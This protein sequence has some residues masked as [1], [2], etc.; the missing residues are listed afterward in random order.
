L[1]VQLADIGDLLLAAPAV[2][3]FARARPGL[4][5]SLLTKPANRPLAER[6]FDDVITADKHLYDRPA[7][8]ARPG[9]LVAAAR[10]VLA[11]RR[12]KF[13]EVIL[14][15]HLTT[16]FGAAKWALLSL[17]TG[18]KIRRG[19]DNGRGWFLSR[20]T[21]DRGFGAANEETYWAEMLAGVEA[22]DLEGDD[23]AAQDL[24]AKNGVGGQFAVLHPGSGSYSVARR[25]PL[26]HYAT[27]ARLLA[28]SL[29]LRIVVVGGPEESELGAA[30]VAAHPHG[31]VSLSGRTDFPTLVAVLR[32]AAIFVGNNAGVAQIASSLGT[33]SV[34]IFGPTSPATWHVPSPTSRAVRLD[35]ACSPCF[36]VDHRLG[37]PEGC[38]TREC[39]HDLTP[40]RV[41]EEVTCLLGELNA[42]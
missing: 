16:S 11:L 12:R 14:L 8:A 32:R 9:S 28:C 29:G 23:A 19:L 36:Y 33:P 15:H 4:R 42:A 35:L 10:L 17:L 2:R 26:E 24:L 40:T 13:D 41:F 5:I 7:G 25:W 39:L 22:I 6:L 20:R 21:R 31:V 3:H 18:A 37:T 1:I 38:R 30:L 34:V 27:L